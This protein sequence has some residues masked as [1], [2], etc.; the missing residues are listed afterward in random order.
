M[1]FASAVCYSVN[2][3]EEETEFISEDVILL[4]DENTSNAQIENWLSVAGEVLKYYS[5]YSAGL[6]PLVTE[7]NWRFYDVIPDKVINLTDAVYFLEI[8]S[9]QGAGIEFSGYIPKRDGSYSPVTTAVTTKQTTSEITSATSSSSDMPQTTV[10]TAKPTTTSKTNTTTAKTT[11]TTKTNTTTAKTTTTTKTNTTTAKTTTT[12]K[13]NTT[14][15]KTTTITKTNT[16]NAKTT[17]SKPV[18][19]S[20]SK[21]MVS[22]ITSD[23][24]DTTSVT[25]TT[26]VTTTVITRPPLA[27]GIDVSVY[28]GQVDWKAVKE[29]G[30]EFAIIRAGYGK[31][32][33]QEDKYFDINMKKA[34]EAGIDCGAYWFSYA[35]TPEDALKEADVFYEVIKD[36]KFEYPIFFD[37]ETSAQYELEPEESTAIIHAFCDRMESYGYYVSLCSYVNFLNTRI[38]PE[39]FESFDTWIAHYNVQVPLFSRNYGIWQYS[40]TGRIPGI[41]TDV[42]LNY[43]YYNYPN[44]MIKN[45]LNGF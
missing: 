12:T 23:S 14:T 28:Q 32:I 34:K 30:V 25:S 10:T 19:S 9:L 1:F 21:T 37:Y 35:T 18:I 15:A 40:C 33:N 8:Y 39:I 43:A 26:T 31:H 2:A 36:Y 17:T 38:E 22:Q 16:T 44:I 41:E 6:E 27:S 11:T 7:R 42:D 13:T 24:D 45:N 3:E 20:S 29:S 4:T 5:E